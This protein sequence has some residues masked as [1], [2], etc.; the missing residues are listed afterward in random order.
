MRKLLLVEDDSSL[1]YLLT[2][3]LKMKDFQIVWATNGIEALEIL[4]KE[5]FDLIILDVMMP[6]MDGFTLAEKIRDLYSS[7]PFMFLSA[8][9]LKIDVLK[10]FSLGAVDYLKKPI[11]EEEL[12]VR[13][14][15]LLNRLNIGINTSLQEE[16]ILGGYLFNPATQ[17]L[18]YKDEIISLTSR[19]SELL[20]FLWRRKNEL[21]LHK[22]ILTSIWG[23]NDYFNRKSLNVFISHLRKYLS[24]DPRIVI[25]N[26]HNKGFLLKVKE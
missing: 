7:I 26:V 20:L 9:S 14:E 8:R 19:E 21:S 25:E 17:E 18:K 2:E 15:A 5:V 22:D 16:I 3:Y 1:G 11:D 6:E 13:V 4:K 24:K 10:G 23:E 12:V